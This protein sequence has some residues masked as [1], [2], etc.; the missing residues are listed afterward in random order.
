ML[1]NA[2]GWS[3]PSGFARKAGTWF[4]PQRGLDRLARTAGVENG[5]KAGVMGTGERHA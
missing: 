1:A 2:I 5:S 3:V 4:Q